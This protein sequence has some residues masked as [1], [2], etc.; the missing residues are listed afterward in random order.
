MTILQELSEFV[1]NLETKQ[2][3]KEV[4]KCVKT[5]ILHH[6]YTGFSGIN[7]HESRMAL[8]IASNHLGD[9]GKCTILGQKRKTSVIGAAFANC[10][11]M[12]SIQQEDTY[13]GLHPGPHTIPVA[14]SL[15]EELSIS[16]NQILSSIVAGYETNNQIGDLCMKLTS[17]KG[18]RGTTIFGVLGAA[19]TGARVLEL[20]QE[21]TMNA[22]ANS[23]NMAS[24]LM[25]CW[26]SGTS[27]WLY[28]SGVAAQNGVLS[29]LLA[30]EGADGSSTSFEGNKG[31]FNAYCGVQP[32]NASALIGELGKRYTIPDV[33]LKSY[34]VITSIL[35][36]IHNV[37]GLVN[38]NS[39]SADQVKSVH[40]TAGSRVTEGPLQA[41]ILDFGPYTNKTQAFKSL[42]CATGIA[43]KFRNVTAQTVEHYQD[44]DVSRLAK[45]VKVSTDKSYEGYYSS[46][47]I[48]TADGSNFETSGDEFPTLT[49]KQV[50][51]N[52]KNVASK[53]LPLEKIE[54][55]INLINNIERVSM[56]DISDCLS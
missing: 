22:I 30:K 9:G 54:T 1:S 25:E 43:L 38:E 40:I 35:P 16:G 49:D 56:S 18:W 55:L 32:E 34:S 13:K 26:L 21:K 53:Y 3:P 52:L 29:A 17:A 11:L 28:A 36:V 46:V 45:L 8:R 24:G 31:F 39:I 47:E 51:T 19:A 15:S 33:T 44:A 41:S 48:S 6:L 12:H 4:R 14:F 7:E 50:V 27:E 20:D 23:V 37:V 10:V 5:L 42:P 2:I